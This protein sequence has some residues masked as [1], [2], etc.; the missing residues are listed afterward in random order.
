MK[1]IEENVG[2]AIVNIAN[3]ITMKGMNAG[4]DRANT[5]EALVA[6][7]KEAQTPE[8]FKRIVDDFTSDENID[9]IECNALGEDVENII[10]SLV[11]IKN[12]CDK[13]G[14]SEESDKLSEM[15]GVMDHTP[16]EQMSRI[17]KFM[18]DYMFRVDK[19]IFGTQSNS[20]RTVGGMIDNSMVEANPEYADWDYAACLEG[21][22]GGLFKNVGIEILFRCAKDS[23]E[24]LVSLK[25]H[26]PK[27]VSENS[28][29]YGRFVADLGTLELD[30]LDNNAQ[31]KL[32][33]LLNEAGMALS[34]LILKDPKIDTIIPL[35]EGD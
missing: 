1:K 12:S 16:Y 14:F 34:G 6:E 2:A 3:I 10:H 9:I 8:S 33:N 5:I 31:K 22:N 15:I 35:G 26:R 32:C 23:D 29:S 11:A 28:V 21:S 7:M 19:K 13:Y 4:D 17:Q 20:S 25:A 18:Q 30:I 27:Y 24:A